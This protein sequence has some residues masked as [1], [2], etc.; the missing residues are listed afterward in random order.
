MSA[1]STALHFLPSTAERGFEIVQH[2]IVPSSKA[3]PGFV[4]LLLLRDPN[5]GAPP[6][7]RSGSYPIQ[8]AKVAEFLSGPP[9]R[10]ICEVEEVGVPR[11]QAG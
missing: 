1:R 11:L 5:M 7:S 9:T 8:M 4:G 10:H 6:S 2:P 3:R